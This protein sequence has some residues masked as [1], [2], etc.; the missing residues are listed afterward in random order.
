AHRFARFVDQPLRARL[1]SWSSPFFSELDAVLAPEFRHA[2]PPAAPARAETLESM[3]ALAR[4][5]RHN[6]AGYLV[7]DLLVKTDRASMA[8]ALEARSPFLDRALVEYVM[9][10]PDAYKMWLGRHKIILREAFAD[11]VPAAI[12][13]RRKM[14][15]GVPL[16]RW[17]RGELRSY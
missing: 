6:F 2:L 9:D 13:T 14:G 11:L 12:M 10:L 1:E 5:L 16:G 17:F 7:D 15:F 8:H 4:A 3:T